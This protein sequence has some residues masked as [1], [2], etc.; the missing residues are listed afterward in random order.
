MLF[1]GAGS[2]LW[3]SSLDHGIFTPLVANEEGDERETYG[4]RAWGIRG[5]DNGVRNYL[6]ASQ[7]IDSSRLNYHVFVWSETTVEA[8]CAR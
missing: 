1:P 8:T 6:F 7:A 2:W 3:Y 5:G 4:S